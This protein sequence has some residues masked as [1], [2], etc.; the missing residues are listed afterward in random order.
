MAIIVLAIH[1]V[2]APGKQTDVLGYL[3]KFFRLGIDHH[4]AGF[5][6]VKTVTHIRRKLLGP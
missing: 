2:R 5:N 3:L 1:D 4:E 6:V